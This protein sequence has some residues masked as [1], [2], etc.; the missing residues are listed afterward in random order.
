MALGILEPRVVDDLAD[1]RVEPQHV[2]A[3]C[4]RRAQARQRHDLANQR[5]E[6]LGL[7][8]DARKIGLRFRARAPLRERER[9][10]DS[11]ERRAQLVRDVAQQSLLRRDQCLNALGHRVEV[12]GQ[13][14]DLVAAAR[15]RRADARLERA[16]GERAA[17]LLQPHD[18]RR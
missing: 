5:V 18:R 14:A 15:E 1:E 11:G 12:P 13:R 2:A 4:V 3:R 16:G 6:P 8:L 17:R 7:A 10:A 9:H